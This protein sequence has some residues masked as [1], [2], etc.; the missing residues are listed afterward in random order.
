MR[1]LPTA[2]AVTLVGLLVVGLAGCGRKAKTDADSADATPNTPPPRPQPQPNP[3]PEPNP[4][5]NDPFGA[6]PFVPGTNPDP[7]MPSGMD[8]QPQPQPQPNPMPVVPQPEPDKKDPAMVQPQPNPKPNPMAVIPQPDPKLP[9][10][11][12]KDPDKKDPMMGSVPDWPK[13]IGGK[14]AK[15][16]VKD[17]ID[18]DPAVR[19]IALKTLPGFGPP[20]RKATT[21][22]GKITIGKALLARMDVANERDTQVRA[23]AFTAAAAIGFDEDLD[24]KEA[25]RILGTTVDGNSL[26]RAHAL[27]ALATFGSRGEPAIQY[28]VT[29]PVYTDPSYETRRSL[30]ATLGLIGFNEKTGPNPRALSCLTTHLMIDRSAAVR[31]ETM[32]ALVW[33][34]PPVQKS[35]APDPRNPGSMIEQNVTDTKAAAVY[36]AAIKKRLAPPPKGMEGTPT[37]LVEP[38]RQ[39]E[40]WARVAVMRFDP[41]EVNAE[42]LDGIAKYTNGSDYGAKIQALTALG[43][44]GE[45]GARKID[46]VVKALGSDDPTVVYTAVSALAAMGPAAKPAIPELERLKTRGK[47][48]ENK[49]YRTLADEAIKVI[50]APPGGPAM[51]KKP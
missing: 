36:V 25:V 17:L 28:L 14:D 10:P 7:M 31:L 9:P 15:A 46:D 35:M 29:T 4:N 5:P 39:V 51:E 42:N 50:K 40:V 12:S 33:L 20:V 24:T 2:L 34:G 16:Y 1:R 6:L 38:N 13:E 45:M 30:A 32:Q 23:S 21:P 47:D 18:P 48:G 27:Q 11:P 44:M 8:P 37:G 19:E 49:Y 26:L 43:L 3:N 22:D 41:T